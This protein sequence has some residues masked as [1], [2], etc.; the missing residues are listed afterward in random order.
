MV[1]V[2]LFCGRRVSL[3]RRKIND[4][5]LMN[6]IRLTEKERYNA[7]NKM[8]DVAE[9]ASSFAMAKKIRKPKGAT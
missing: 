9:K 6:L 4:P 8:S 3:V 1:C 5:S 2:V 7:I